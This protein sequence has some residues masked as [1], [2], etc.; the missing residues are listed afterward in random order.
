MLGE[1]HLF[2]DK[3]KAGSDLELYKDSFSGI[4]LQG[5]YWTE[6]SI[7][8][9]GPIVG[10][11]LLEDSIIDSGKIK[12]LVTN[13]DIDGN[14]TLCL[15]SK[16]AWSTRKVDS[17]NTLRMLLIEELNT[18]WGTATDQVKLKSLAEF[19]DKTINILFKVNNGK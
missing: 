7:S 17:K 18:Y 13:I 1:V 8:R 12:F 11:L 6:Y 2:S 15:E 5:P 10:E 16:Y 4:H 14:Y 9:I 3:D 19:L